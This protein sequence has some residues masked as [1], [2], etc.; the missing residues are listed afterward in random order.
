MTLEQ[1]VVVATGTG[2]VTI[3][4]TGFLVNQGTILGKDERADLRSRLQAGFVDQRGGR[5][6]G[7]L[8]GP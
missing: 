1:G 5:W 6:R 2:N 8:Q 7:W 3:N 4:P